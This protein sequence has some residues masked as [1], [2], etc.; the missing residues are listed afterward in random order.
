MTLAVGSRLG[1]YE[2]LAPIG[3]VGMGEVYRVRDSKLGRD[4]AIKAPPETFAR[5]ADRMACFGR[6]AKLL[7]ALNYTNMAQTVAIPRFQ[8]LSMVLKTGRLA[9][10]PWSYST[11]IADT[12]IGA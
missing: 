5:D 3:A 9:H 8:L 6:E 11:C 4:V 12:D 1:P 10:I 2:I 7:A